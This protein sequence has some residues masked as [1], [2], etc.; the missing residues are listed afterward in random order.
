MT[1]KPANT[2]V[3][4]TAAGVPKFFGHIGQYR[5]NRA[6]KITRPIREDDRL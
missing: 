2:P 3:V 5:G 1:E 6:I 4:V